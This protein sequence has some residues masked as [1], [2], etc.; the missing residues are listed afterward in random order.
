MSL[1][2]TVKIKLNQTCAL[3]YQWFFISFVEIEERKSR[4]V[5]KKGQVTFSMR[6]VPELNGDIQLLY[7]I[8]TVLRIANIRKLRA[9]MIAK[10]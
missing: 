9:Q 7:P 4:G 3:I 10:F 8:G 1:L 5:I 2:S 6:T